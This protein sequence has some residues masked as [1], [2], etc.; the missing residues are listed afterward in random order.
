M[1]DT[2]TAVKLLISYQVKEDSSQAYY[3]FVMG[4]LLPIV[5]EQGLQMSEAWHTAYGDAPNRLI[6]FVSADML[7]MEDFL[8]SDIW[9]Q[10]YEQLGEYVIDLSYKVIPYRQGFQL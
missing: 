3:Q 5:Q 8:D 2:S 6:G 1:D 4:Q 7:T 10:L 9:Q